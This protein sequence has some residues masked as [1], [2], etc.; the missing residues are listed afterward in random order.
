MN[1]D[2]ALKQAGRESPLRETLPVVGNIEREPTGKVRVYP[3]P[4][5]LS[6]YV[7]LDPDS[8]D[9]EIVDVT[10][11]ARSQDPSRRGPVYAVPVRKGAEIQIVSVTTVAVT[12]VGRMRFLSLNQ[13]GG[14]G[15]GGRG[16][17][18]RRGGGCQIG[19]CTTVG[20]GQYDCFEDDPGTGLIYCSG[21]CLIAA[22]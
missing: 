3:D 11:H 7:L 21:C 2:E 10:E 17:K 12:D 22:Q 6:R 15:C 5:D 4:Y 16:D 9:G 13:S 14:C 1:I 20:G 19:H 18:E 8:V